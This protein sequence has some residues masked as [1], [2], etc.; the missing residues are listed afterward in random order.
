MS[1]TGAV[2]ELE[3]VSTVPATGSDA[4]SEA[5]CCVLMRI[6]DKGT[7]TDSRLKGKYEQS[8]NE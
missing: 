1:E 6:S 8:V 3:A 4:F 7:V 5:G 2:T